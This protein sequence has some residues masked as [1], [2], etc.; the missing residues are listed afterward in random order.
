MLHSLDGLRDTSYTRKS[1]DEGLDQELNRLDAQREPGEAYIASRRGQGWDCI[2]CHCG[3]RGYTGGNMN[4]PALSQQPEGARAGLWPVAGA[5]GQLTASTP[6]R[7]TDSRSVDRCWVT[8]VQGTDGARG[9]DASTTRPRR[10][11][12]RMKTGVGEGTRTPSPVSHSHV[13]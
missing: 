9:R 11:L 4:R 10:H 12:R 3:N 7:P 6:A 13:L 2:P 1:T 8:G 5:A